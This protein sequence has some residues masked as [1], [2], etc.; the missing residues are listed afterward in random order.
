M[1]N[2]VLYFRICLLR[3][4]ADVGIDDAELALLLEGVVAVDQHEQHTPQHPDIHS[5]V[6]WVF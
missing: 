1:P 3:R 2:Q 5:V 6:H 4:V